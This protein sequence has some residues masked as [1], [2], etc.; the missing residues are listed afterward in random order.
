VA[1]DYALADSG[2]TAAVAIFADPDDSIDAYTPDVMRSEIKTPRHCS[3]LQAIDFPISTAA[4][5]LSGV[6]AALLQRFGRRF[7]YLLAANRADVTGARA[8]EIG[9]GWRGDETPFSIPA[10]RYG[11]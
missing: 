10:G 1:A 11:A 2:G 4:V 8:A 5:G 7:G 6:A 3:V 9:A